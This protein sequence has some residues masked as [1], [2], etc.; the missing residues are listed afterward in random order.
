MAGIPEGSE[1]QREYL[2]YLLRLWRAGDGERP[3]WRASLRSAHTGEQVGMA[4]LEELFRFLE[5]QTGTVP[6]AEEDGP[7]P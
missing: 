5:H 7:E 1:E 2:S 3:T 6:N 4:S